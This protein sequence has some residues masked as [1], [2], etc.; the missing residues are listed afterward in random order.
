VCHPS[1]CDDN[2]TGIAISTL[3][4]AGLAAGSRPR[5]TY[6]FLYAPGTIG[7]VTWLQQNREHVDRIV[8]GLTLTCLGDS[9]PLT[10]KRTERARTLI[11]RAAE[12][13]LAR[14]AVD[15]A[16]IDFFPY[17]Y[18][19]RQFNSPGFRLPVGSLMRGR[20]GQFPEYHTSA[21]DR[22]FISETQLI[23]SF[24]VLSRILDVV[25]RDRTMCNVEPFGEPQL[26]SRGLYRAL[27]GTDIADAQLSMLWILNQSDG[28]RSLLDIAERSGMRFASIS[29]TAQLLEQHGLLTDVTRRSMDPPVEH[30]A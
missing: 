6:R 30:D 3:L 7:A 23:E 17:G 28:T 2:L 18:D 20:H 21:D 10:F 14:S 5:R 11:D 1:L 29:A 12:H 4:A 19:E 8:A 27:G 15:H 26:G 9:H 24:E 16:V 22:S 13:V 25:D